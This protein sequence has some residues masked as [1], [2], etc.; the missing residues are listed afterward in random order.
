[1]TDFEP[2]IPKPEDNLETSLAGIRQA[3]GKN[4]GVKLDSEEF[5]WL[6]AVGGLRGIVESVCPTLVFIV[7]FVVGLDVFIA[8]SI[9]LGMALCLILLR[10]VTKS[11][12][13][14]SLA[15]FFGVVIGVVW[16]SL[17]GRGQDFFALGLWTNIV[18]L[19]VFLI[20]ILLRVPVIGL[21][22]G[23]FRSQGLQWRRDPRLKADK[24]AYYA[25]TLLWA[26]MF[27][28]RL[29]IKVPM[30]FAGEVAWLGTFQ[31][32]LGVPLFALVLYLSWLLLRRTRGGSFLDSGLNAG[33]AAD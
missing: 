17:S 14:Q 30:Y 33:S 25:V 7:A 1:M 26:A 13:T 5:S 12:V 22:V 3:V 19:A 4:L 10:I 21:M 9:A 28:L 16:A 6:A 23:W 20:S 24:K 15:G 32:L 31:L 18:Y 2:Q 27:A 29:A 8:A 11:G